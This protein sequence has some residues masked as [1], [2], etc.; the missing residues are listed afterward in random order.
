[1]SLLHA[2]AQTQTAALETSTPGYNDLKAEI[3]YSR[4][5]DPA[6]HGLSEVTLGLRGTNLLDDVIRNAASFRKDE[7]VLPGRNVRLFL[8]ARF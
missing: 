7:V 6:V 8:T 2:F 4:P 1:M 3:A 5:L